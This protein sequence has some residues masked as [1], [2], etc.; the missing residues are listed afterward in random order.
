MLK[1]IFLLKVCI[2]FAE[3]IN[4]IFINFSRKK[5]YIV[6]CL[7]NYEHN[8]LINKVLIIF[9]EIA[10]SS[11]IGFITSFKIGNEKAFLLGTVLFLIIETINLR[12][13][14]QKVSAYFEEIVS[15]I[16]ILKPNDAVSE[17]SL[18]YCLK[19]I[20]SIKKD[21]IRVDKQYVF[22]F[23]RDCMIRA[24]KSWS[25]ISY[26]SPIE[27]WKLKGW[28][29]FSLAA[30]KERIA[31]GCHIERIFCV[32]DLSEK[33]SLNEEFQS[34]IE[35]GVEAYWVLK[36]HLFSNSIIKE[37]FNSLQSIDIALIDNSWILY[38]HLDNKRSFLGAYASRNQELVKI[39]SFLI[40][41][42]RR[43]SYKI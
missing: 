39:A 3:L 34:Q 24:E 10:F 22:E 28:N 15:L 27:T 6:W 32:D 18:K 8:S 21:S 37:K 5:I 38:P 26:T 23:W 16:E 9:I 42:A 41:E 11:F 30:Q 35:I 13:H 36:D 31:N 19:N 4:K 40:R 33:E 29:T 12:F 20:A 2:S 7:M 14:A 25:I 1:N 43:L 17:L